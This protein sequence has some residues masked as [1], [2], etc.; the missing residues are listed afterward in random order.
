MFYDDKQFWFG[1]GD[2]SAAS[3]VHGGRLC[4][5]I[6]RAP[7]CAFGACALWSR[8]PTVDE[9]G[10][11]RGGFEGP[12]LVLLQNGKLRAGQDRDCARTF[13]CLEVRGARHAGLRDMPKTA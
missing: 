4:D 5:R 1:F 2:R 8:T 7:F 10:M 13:Q 6:D 9:C 12:A 3:H 11:R